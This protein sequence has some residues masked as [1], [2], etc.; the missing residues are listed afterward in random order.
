MRPM[1]TRI[2]Q[3]SNRSAAGLLDRRHPWSPSRGDPIRLGIPLALTHSQLQCLGD[4][5]KDRIRQAMAAGSKWVGTTHTPTKIIASGVAER[6]PGATP[7]PSANR[8][9]V[10]AGRSA[11]PRSPRGRRHRFPPERPRPRRAT[12]PAGSRGSLARRSSRPPTSGV[13]PRATPS[14]RLPQ[15]PGQ[16][17]GGSG[18]VAGYRRQDSSGDQSSARRPPNRLVR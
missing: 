15:A 6:R 12:R 13:R 16:I 14:P 18:D 2:P 7:K 4:G 8:N 3:P 11:R 17:N 10:C 9:S 1:R 5:V